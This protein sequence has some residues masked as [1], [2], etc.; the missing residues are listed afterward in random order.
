MRKMDEKICDSNSTLH[1]ICSIIA[2][3]FLINFT[4]VI[5]TLLFAFFSPL[6]CSFI[7]RF[8]FYSKYL[9]HKKITLNDKGAEPFC[10]PLIFNKILKSICG[11]NSV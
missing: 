2:V 11:K 5:V 6:L 10:Y 8:L 4:L 7:G 3:L 1:F 9:K